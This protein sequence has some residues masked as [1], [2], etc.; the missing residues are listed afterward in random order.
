MSIKLLM[1]EW[2]KRC[3]KLER[4]WEKWLFLETAQ[5]SFYIRGEEGGRK[6]QFFPNIC[7]NNFLH[8]S[9]NEQRMK[10]NDYFSYYDYHT[11]RFDDRYIYI[12]LPMMC[13]NESMILGMIYKLKTVRFL[14]QWLSFHRYT[15][16]DIEYIYMY[17]TYR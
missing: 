14:M 13:M 2:C 7:S 5:R 12:H 9:I 1:N 11:Y 3:T 8:V 10:W 16:V 17:R 4:G 15:I 6:L